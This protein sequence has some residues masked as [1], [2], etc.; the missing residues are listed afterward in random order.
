MDVLHAAVL[1]L[2]QG[3]TEFLPI[4]SSGHLVLADRLLFGG[5]ALPLW[6]DIASNTGTFLAA[7]LLMRREL[8]S[9]IAGLLAGLGSKKA[10]RGPGWRLFWLVA[11]ASVPAAVVGLLV[12]D[13]FEA[14]NRPLFVGLGLLFTALVLWTTPQG[15]AAATPERVGYRE[16]FLAGLAQAL[17]IWPGVSRSGTTISAFLRLGVAPE[18]AARLSFLMYA[19]A[20]LGVLLLGLKDGL[21]TGVEPAPVLA[22]VAA[23]FVSGYAAML[24]LFG[25]LRAGKFRLFAP[26]VAAVA[27]LALLLR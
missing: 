16:A 5:K 3:L 2:V 12:K 11:V 25:V 15:G 1:G 14:I 20:S 8:A 24:L 18:F 17:A 13:V 7:L 21:P 27:A 6:V 23:A 9:A 10:R 26:Y 19:A 22:M 4:S